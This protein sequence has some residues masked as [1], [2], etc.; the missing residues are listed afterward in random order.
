[1]TYVDGVR[2]YDF[3]TVIWFWIGSSV[4]SLILATTLWRV[5]LSD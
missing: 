3:S 5:R 1:M 4:I 2:H